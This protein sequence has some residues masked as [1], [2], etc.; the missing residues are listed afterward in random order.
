MKKNLSFRL[1]PP[2]G[3]IWESLN[4]LY[5]CQPPHPT[6]TA[7]PE[8]STCSEE[9]GRASHALTGPTVQ[10]R[11]KSTKGPEEDRR[12]LLTLY[13]SASPVQV[14]QYHHAGNP[15]RVYGVALS[16]SA[17]THPALLGSRGYSRGAFRKNP[18]CSRRTRPAICAGIILPSSGHCSCQREVRP[19]LCKPPSPGVVLAFFD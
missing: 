9:A 1:W 17:I 5:P 10:R 15:R 18:D 16:T 14:L 7:L 11:S 6:S 4:R 8:V 13:T 19:L 3:R 12:D 2:T